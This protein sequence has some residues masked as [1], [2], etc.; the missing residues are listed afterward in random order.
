MKIKKLFSRASF[1][2]GSHFVRAFTIVFACAFSLLNFTGCTKL[3]KNSNKTTLVTS[4]YPVHIILMN[5]I[6]DVDNIEIK[7][8]S[9][10]HSGCLHNFQLQSEDLKNIELSSA[11]IING[12]GM[13]TFLDKVVDENPEITIIDSSSNIE[14][15][16]ECESHEHERDHD[17]CHHDCHCEVNPHIWLSP[18]NYVCQIQNI[19]EGLKKVDPENSKKYDEN[20]EVYI[21]K[22]IN[23]KNKMHSEL[24]GISKKDIITFHNAFPYFAK[25]FGLN[26]SG[27]INHEAGEEPSAKEILEIVDI[28]N[29]K[30]IPAVFVEPQYSCG[31]ADTIAKE[32]GSKVY[33]LNPAVTGELNED[34]YIATMEKNAEIL[35]V[36]LA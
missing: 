28:I 16:H 22:I 5:L 35:K 10:N 30:N 34:S 24:D 27:V 14:T 20:A 3:S 8:M 29:E 25:E 11:F 12:A 26:I 2:F 15:I 36:A 4:C 17:D 7:K 19:S 32:T 6:K 31:I 18:E 9:E 21:K 23:L 13:E 1:I 33:T